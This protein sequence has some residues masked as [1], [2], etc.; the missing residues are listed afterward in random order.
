MKKILF[1]LLLPLTLFG[2]SQKISDM[3]S[4]TSLTGSEYVPIVQTT[5]KKATVGLLR[6]W[7]SLGTAG[8]LLKVNAGA[9]AL[10]FFTPPYISA[11]PGAGIAVSTGS[12]WGTSITDNSANWNTAYGWGDHAGLYWSKASGGTLTGVNTI[13]SNAFSQLIFTGTATAGSAGLSFINYGGTVTAYNGTGVNIYSKWNPVFNGNG[14]GNTN[15]VAQ[16]SH[17]GTGGTSPNY[18]DL[19]VGDFTAVTGYLFQA[20]TGYYSGNFRFDSNIR[21]NRDNNIVTQSS[22]GA[23]SNRTLTIGNTSY[24]IIDLSNKGVVSFTQSA[25]ASVAPNNAFKIT[26]GAHTALTASTE[27]NDISWDLN[28][29][30]QHAAGAITNQRWAYI[31]NPTHSFVGS[32]TSAREVTV[33]IKGAPIAGTNATFTS[34]IGLEVESANVTSGTVNSYGAYLNAQSGATNNNALGL[35]GNISSENNFFSIN[36]KALAT[37]NSGLAFDFS[38][39]GQFGLEAF[40]GTSGSTTGNTLLFSGGDG[41]GSGNTNAGSISFQSGTP[42]GSGTEGAVN[43]QARSTGKLG[44]FNSSAVVKQSAV[45]TTQGIAD[46]LTA[47]GLLPS[48]TISDVVVDDVVAGTTLT[49]DDADN[50]KLIY[51]TSSSA[52]TVTL[53]SGLM[54]GFYVMLVQDNTGAI[55]VSPSGTTLNGNSTTA[56]QYD[57]LTLTNYKAANTYIGK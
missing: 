50:G 8:Q 15:I 3:T 56:S 53:P 45:T 11:Y 12:A 42:F 47:Y 46:A 34:S 37:T 19:M 41:Y 51:F 52:I 23:S 25:L 29:T 4:A 39:D 21:D 35:S 5:N 49:L 36:N 28:R 30:V 44:F 18:V 22:S 43:I 16:F 55:S 32:S 7:T 48:S 6:G 10:E 33:A 54:D 38:V 40:T 2:Q 57:V 13:T 27:I 9:T 31:K 17:T 1:I 26:G 14:S 24:S 20:Q